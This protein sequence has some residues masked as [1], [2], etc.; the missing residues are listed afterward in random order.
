[1]TSQVA[2]GTSLPRSWRDRTDAT[3]HCRDLVVADRATKW[4][5]R[6]RISAYR[7][8]V[9]SQPVNQ[10]TGQPV[11]RSPVIGSP[12]NRSPVIRSPV[13][14]VTGHPVTGHPVSRSAG[15]PVAGQPTGQ[16]VNRSPVAGQPVNRSPVSR[17]PVAGQPVNRSTG[18]G[19]S[20]H[21]STGR[22]SARPSA[23]SQ[24]TSSRPT[25]SHTQSV[26]P[27]L[28]FTAATS[29]QQLGSSGD[30]SP[31][32][33]ECSGV[34]ES[35]WEEPPD[36]RR[37]LFPDS[38]ASVGIPVARTD[39][40]WASTTSRGLSS[41]MRSV[42]VDPEA[43]PEQTSSSSETIAEALRLI[44][45]LMADKLPEDEATILQHS[46]TASL[47]A[48]D[49]DVSSNE[50]IAFQTLPLSL[51]V[52]SAVESRLKNHSAST[53]TMSSRRS[54]YQPSTTADDPEPLLLLPLPKVEPGFE[55]LTGK[56][57]L[58]SKILQDTSFTT[59]EL[60][61]LWTAA[62]TR[63]AIS[64]T[65]DWTS[66]AIHRAV[67]HIS[68]LILEEEETELRQQLDGVRHLL[69]FLGKTVEDGFKA[70]AA[71]ASIVTSATR[72]SAR[73]RLPDLS[74]SQK[75]G[76]AEVPLAGSSMFGGRLLDRS[77]SEPSE[78]RRGENRIIKA[79]SSRPRAPASG[80]TFAFPS[81]RAPRRNQASSSSSFSRGPMRPQ[82]SAS[83]R[84]N[85][86]SRGQ[87]SFSSS[88]PPRGGGRGASSSTFRS[89]SRRRVW[90]DAAFST[91][92]RHSIH[93][94]KWAEFYNISFTNGGIKAALLGY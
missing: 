59:T 69:C 82:P 83:A 28:S 77:L 64:S 76:L 31:T 86:R 22:G 45:H 33:L 21:R 94:P 24:R 25:A 91:T 85:S 80:P 71:V 42:S 56:E 2:S 74:S 35:A 12:V 37:W 19:S 46:G 48:A 17:S 40:Q 73:K 81:D 7:S 20:S 88:A 54:A 66:A 51:A 30:E 53:H 16:P 18:H 92:S 57:T 52:K 47:L 67:A 9:T 84:G 87:R 36:K 43:R 55:E 11:N 15:Q 29:Q 4:R 32:G 23:S 13:N 34:R 65:Q 78:K 38:L 3:E 50:S 14:L 70:D 62:R 41:P 27:S 44:R 63:L 26:D 75:A 49:L 72:K 61:D 39:P 8:P 93:L 10:S 58:V 68:A 6:S 90:R 1:M 89:H 5:T 79:L 60:K